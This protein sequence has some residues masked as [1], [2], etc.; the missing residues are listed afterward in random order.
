MPTPDRGEDPAW[1][2][3]TGGDRKAASATGSRKP[4][5]SCWAR[6]SS[7]L[8]GWAIDNKFG[9]S[10]VFTVLFAV[11]GIVAATV[12]LY[13]RYKLAVAQEDEGK[14]WNRRRQ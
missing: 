7:G 10:P 14:P 1:R 9:T 11:F 8:L 13:F 5:S 12:T 6:S 3:A 4:W 2:N